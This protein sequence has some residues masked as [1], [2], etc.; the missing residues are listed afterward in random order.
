M[1]QFRLLGKHDTRALAHHYIA[2][3]QGAALLA[4]TLNDC[5]VFTEQLGQL[6][7][8]LDTL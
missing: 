6:K 2:A 1:A 5:S 7:R 3:M 8:W 4:S